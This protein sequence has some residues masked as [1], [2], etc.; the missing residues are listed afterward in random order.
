MANM[1]ALLMIVYPL[2]VNLM[3]GEDK[4]LINNGTQ[5]HADFRR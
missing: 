1:L 2:G 3:L 5:I 4:K